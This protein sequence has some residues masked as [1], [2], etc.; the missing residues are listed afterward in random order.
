MYTCGNSEHRLIM[1]VYVDD[2]IIIKGDKEV[3][4][5]FKREMSKMRNLRPFSYYLAIEVR[6]N[7]DGISIY[8]GAYAKKILDIARLEDS[9]PSRTPME[10]R[11]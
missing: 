5:S 2:L 11:L 3:L 6:Q 7:G 4:G 10:P 8:Q 9:N 1:E